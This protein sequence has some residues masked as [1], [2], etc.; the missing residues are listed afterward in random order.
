M[1]MIILIMCIYIYIYIYIYI[2]RE[3]C[4]YVYVHIRCMCMYVCIYIYIYIICRYIHIYIYIYA[5]M[6][7]TVTAWRVA[8]CPRTRW[9][10]RAPVPEG[11][12][13]VILFCEVLLFDI[14][15]KFRWNSGE[16]PATLWKS[17]LKKSRKPTNKYNSSS[18]RRVTLKGVPRKG[19]CLVT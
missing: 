7:Q 16:I 5:S 12:V 9:E 1:I 15:V 4:I 10:A 14:L 13:V 11:R 6:G 8:R 17:V 19:Y 2:E 3:R 18:H